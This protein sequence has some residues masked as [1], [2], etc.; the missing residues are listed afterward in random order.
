MQNDITNIQSDSVL[1]A[2]IGSKIPTF[3]AKT[4]FMMQ[5]FLDG[6][7]FT[8]DTI[9]TACFLDFLTIRTSRES[10]EHAQPKLLTFMT[11]RILKLLS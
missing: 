10:Q 2:M 7:V 9:T 8:T 4:L 5:N 11:Y 6:H 1:S 3:Q